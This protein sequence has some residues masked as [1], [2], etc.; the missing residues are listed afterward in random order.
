MRGLFLATIL[1]L[2]ASSGAAWADG[3]DAA[4]A[5]AA[6]AK[7]KALDGDDPTQWQEVLDL[8]LEADAVRTTKE[9][10]YEIA[11]AASKVKA[12]DVAV[13]AYEAS[14]ALGLSGPPEEKAK[15]FLAQH[16]AQMGRLDMRGPAGAQVYVAGRR[17]ATLPLAHP[18]VSFAG[19]VHVRV[20]S[21]GK[22]V[23][24]D[25]TL[26]EGQTHVLD[27]GP[28]LAPP[29]PLPTPVLVPVTPSAPPKPDHTVGWALVG[30]GAF[31]TVSGGVLWFLAARTVSARRESLAG[32]CT[33]YDE[34]D[35]DVCRTAATPQ[36]RDWAQ[37]DAN[38]IHTFKPLRVVGAVA[39]GVGVLTMAIGAW[40]LGGK[41]EK[42]AT[43]TP[44]I[45]REGATFT[46][47]MTF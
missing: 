41:S 14:I 40:Q 10:K 39:V 23:E 30:S 42:V 7:E 43:V 31:V 13:E 6:A 3:W 12:D 47:R 19:T 15:E 22:S 25:V 20:V 36:E 28:E 17:R 8:F 27:V 33:S 34:N 18:I 9:S 38:L 45:G 29:A 44:T 16:A 32:V 37:E 11:F 1:A 24:H 21:S 2:A 5:R 26:T 4:M 35:G 46:L